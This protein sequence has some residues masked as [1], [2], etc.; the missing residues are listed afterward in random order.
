M[1]SRS[2]PRLHRIAGVIAIS[3]ALAASLATANVFGGSNRSAEAA[4]P[5]SVGVAPGV[6]LGSDARYVTTE[7]FHHHV[8]T[9][10]LPTDAAA[11][12][13]GD[14]KPDPGPLQRHDYVGHQV[15]ATSDQIGAT[16]G[17]AVATGNPTAATAAAQTGR[18]FYA[19]YLKADTKFGPGGP[20]AVYARLADG[21]VAEFA[22]I[23]N[24]GGNPGSLGGLHQPGFPDP[25]VDIGKQGL[26]DIDIDTAERYLYVVNLFERTVY[27][28]DSWAPDTAARTASLVKLVSPP[29]AG[30]C[31]SDDDWRPFGLRVT[32]AS[33]YLGAMCSAES[34]GNAQDARAQ[35]W[36]FDLAAR[37]WSKTPV[38]VAA[39]WPSAGFHAW[40][41]DTSVNTPDLQ[42]MLTGIDITNDGTMVLGFRARHG[43]MIS[44]ANPAGTKV[45]NGFMTLARPNGP[46][47]WADP[48]TGDPY[49]GQTGPSWSSPAPPYFN[50]L[51]V[52]K[53]GFA[54]EGA[55]VSLPKQNASGLGWEVATTQRDVFNTNS[56]G[57]RWFDAS[58]GASTGG[59]EIYFRDVPR[60]FGK[61]HGLG[62][63]ETMTTW[64]TIGDR[65]WSD[66]NA[67]GLQDASEKGIGSVLLELRATCTSTEKLA[68][69]VTG[70]DGGYRFL[71]EPFVAYAVVVAMENFATG[72]PLAG[73]TYSP[74][75]AGHTSTDSDANPANGCIT[76]APGNREDVNLTY[77]AGLHQPAPVKYAVGDRVWADNDRDGVQ[78]SGEIGVGGVTVELLSG[79]K[80]VAT[81]VTSAAGWYLF[82]SLEAGSYSVRFSMLP[83]GTVFSPTGAGTSATDSDA[84]PSNG[85]TAVFTLGSATRAASAADLVD[86]PTLKASAFNRT[87]DAGINQPEQPAPPTYDKFAVGDRVWFDTN[88]NGIQD[89]GE[90]GV[91]G[92]T[93]ELFSGPFPIATKATSAAGWYVFDDVEPGIYYN[94]LFSG[95]PDGYVLSPTGKGTV[96]T[97][98]NADQTTGRTALFVLDETTPAVTAA[99]LA[100]FPGLTAK[101]ID[102]TID[103]GINRSVVET[104]SVGNRVWSDLNDN[105]V[106]DAGEHGIDGV[107]VTLATAGAPQ[108]AL[109]TMV[110]AG[111]GFYRFDDVSAGQYMVSVS[112]SNFVT[113]HPLAGFTSSKV[114]EAS[115]DADVD[116]NDNG[117]GIEPTPGIAAA[118]VTVGD[119]KPEPVGETDL[120]P[121]GQGAPDASANMTV[122]FGFV[123]PFDVGIAKTI[124]N[125]DLSKG[126]TARYSI[127]VTNTGPV[128]VGNITVA[129]P[130]PQGLT[131]VSFVAPAWACQLSATAVTCTRAAPMV[132]GESSTIEITG[133]VT[134][135]NG[136]LVN[137]ACVLTPAGGGTVAANDCAAATAKVITGMLPKAGGGIVLPMLLWAQALTA[138][139]AWMKTSTRRR[140]PW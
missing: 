14:A 13:F 115:P 98:S 137:T 125:T 27:R 25:Q 124:K 11:V 3:T 122:D 73:L 8:G 134:M 87:I 96:A 54:A 135:A 23:P 129:D 29:F 109:A 41:A 114:D 5:S 140:A 121:T 100:D 12:A 123:P 118:L 111:G 105:G 58:G 17:V 6:K 44:T 110:T 68:T 30:S 53:G 57:V 74:Q 117:L 42:M 95:L 20:G 18:T 99:D 40:K 51:G 84:N 113:G 116:S 47:T 78:E 85:Q 120:G 136:S 106:I 26:G 69:V 103:A 93:V 28:I 82:D 52:D 55:V 108:T 39:G 34:T 15:L 130:A 16:W 70:A 45:G 60:A 132:P 59:E 71:V 91:G 19:A 32:S 101:R 35:V 133:T 92:V 37:T 66:T 10:P 72:G 94:V 139:G 79:T 48:A 119:G 2:H 90:L 128:A 77:D 49:A 83:Q 61:A 67:D 56:K 131:F 97:D 104:F 31:A 126:S 43:D 63:L 89:T 88:R 22:R 4:G 21:S 64:R 80:V 24:A 65:V 9:G 127:T 1:A 102:R 112:A 107:M 46:G 75:V 33:L 38:M 138:L 62:D 7:F 36:A 76:V 86:F 81:T 50:T